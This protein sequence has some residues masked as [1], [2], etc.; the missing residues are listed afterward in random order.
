[1]DLHPLWLTFESAQIQGTRKPT[2]ARKKS[3]LSVVFASDV[4]VKKKKPIPGSGLRAPAKPVAGTRFSPR[5]GAPSPPPPLSRSRA[6]PT[7]GQVGSGQPQDRLER[8]GLATAFS[9]CPHIGGHLSLWPAPDW[10]ISERYDP[11]AIG[12]SFRMPAAAFASP[13]TEG[14]LEP[15]LLPRPPSARM[16]TARR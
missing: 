12:A 2:T 1:V 15:R 8:T 7:G 5:N 16:S 6:P 11:Q 10:G 4:C 3:G 9:F 14:S 13:T